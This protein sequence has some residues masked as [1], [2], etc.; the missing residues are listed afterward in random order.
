MNTQ[1]KIDLD[2]KQSIN[3]SRRKITLAGLTTPVILGLSS[4]PVWAAPANCSFI[5]ALSGNISVNHDVSCNRNRMSSVSPGWYKTHQST[6]ET[7]CGTPLTYS[8]T[9][10]FNDIF[11]SPDV[12]ISST[13]V[14]KGTSTSTVI[15]ANPSLGDCLNYM[16]GV[17]STSG[18]DLHNQ[19]FHYIAALLSA[20]SSILVFPY[21]AQAIIN[22]WGVWSLYST[23]QK[24]QKGEYTVGYIADNGMLL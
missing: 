3:K 5:Q 13:I 24:I 10:K 12:E 23:L 6:W 19:S 9:D 1:H 20:S 18:V 17:G 16:T 2:Q 15:N 8:P 11:S 14:K 22:D 4:R 7:Y 21:S